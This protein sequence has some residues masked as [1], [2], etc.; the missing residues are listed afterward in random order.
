[1]D[2]PVPGLRRRGRGLIHSLI[3]L[4]E[5]VAGAGRCWCCWTTV[6]DSRGLLLQG[7]RGE[8]VSVH[9]TVA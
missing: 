9:L 5:S 1:M 7:G 3:E 2:G 8:G 4:A 6:L